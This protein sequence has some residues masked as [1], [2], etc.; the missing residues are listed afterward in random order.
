M[1]LLLRCFWFGF[2]LNAPPGYC[3]FRTFR[4]YIKE[5]RSQTVHMNSKHRGIHRPLQELGCHNDRCNIRTTCADYFRL[6]HSWV[7]SLCFAFRRNSWAV[8]LSLSCK[9]D[10]CGIVR[11]RNYWTQVQG[12][13]C[14]SGYL[15]CQGGQISG[16]SKKTKQCTC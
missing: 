10:N 2:I 14:R 12:H 8:T 1:S 16:P 11:E 15:Q 6:T 7:N 4:K 13:C 5:C 3:Y 9:A